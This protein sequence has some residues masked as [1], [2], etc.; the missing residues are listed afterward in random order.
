METLSELVDV[1]RKKRGAVIMAVLNTTPDSFFD[2][3]KYFDHHGAQQGI[4][5]A[6]R[7]GA[8]IIDVG[9][10]STR[11]GAKPISP[12]EQIDRA[13]PAICH[14]VR[15]GAAVS[16]D[17][18]SSI[19]ALEALRL[20]ATIVNDVSCLANEKLASVT[21]A[22][23][24]DL[25]I[26]HSRGSMTTMSGFSQCAENEY[27]DVVRDVFEEWSQ[28]RER[29]IS[30]GLQKS[31]IWFDP[32]LGFHKNAEHCHEIMRRLHEFQ[33]LEAP[34]LLGPSRKSFIGQL[35]QSP[36]DKRLGGTIAA[37]LHALQAGVKI[38]RVHDVHDVSQAVRAFEAWSPPLM[39]KQL[40][41][42]PHSSSGINQA[43]G[44]LR[45]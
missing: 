2:G 12:Q 4:E 27:K 14:A 21:A 15:C 19:V 42:V 6:L 7:E 34:I 23:N 3:G 10:E 32:G 29:A 45:A 31:R 25:I 43:S 24:G 22:A 8:D 5:R 39:Q 11:P 13:G 33:E 16:I 9:A 20:G 1:V 28:A 38:L 17:T 37:C 41:P 18:T 30:A 36:A 26:M 40:R 35:D 44:A